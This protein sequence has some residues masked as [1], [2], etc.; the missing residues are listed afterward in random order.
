MQY[1][2]AVLYCHLWPVRLYHI[3]PH[4]L[5]NCIIFGKKKAIE[6][7]MCFDFLNKN[8]MGGAFGTYVRQES[9]IQGFG[10]GHLRERV[11]L[12]DLGVNG[13]MILKWVF[14]KWDG[15]A[16]TGLPWLRIGISCRLL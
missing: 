9:C 12:E 11:N 16:W 6:H 13:R 10:G 3:F 14:K 7:K 15:E 8:E 5:I 4:Y 2:C 1:A